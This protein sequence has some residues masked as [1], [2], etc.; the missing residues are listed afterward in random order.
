MNPHPVCLKQLQ[1]DLG[2][3]T[4]TVA[5]GEERL[6]NIDAK[7]AENTFHMHTNTRLLFCPDTMLKILHSAWLTKSC[8]LKHCHVP[9]QTQTSLHACSWKDI[10]FLLGF[11]FSWTCWKLQDGTQCWGWDRGSC[12]QHHLWDINI[13]V[14][15]ARD[16]YPVIWRPDKII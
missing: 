15:K 9:L 6:S 13:Q 11:K 8:A 16:I 1:W 12:G 5:V 4:L 2:L 7:E 10:K 14:K 3:R